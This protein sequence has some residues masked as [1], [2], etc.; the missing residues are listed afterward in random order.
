MR[1]RCDVIMRM[2]C[3][4]AFFF[5]TSTSRLP[6]SADSAFS[7]CTSPYWL[8]LLSCVI[9]ARWKKVLPIWELSTCF[10]CLTFY[11][12]ISCLPLLNYSFDLGEPRAW[13]LIR[14]GPLPFLKVP[15]LVLSLRSDKYLLPKTHN[16]TQ[17]SVKLWELAPLPNII[18]WVSQWIY[19]WRQNMEIFCCE[20]SFLA[21]RNFQG[22][23]S[24]PFF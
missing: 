18:V 5:Y 16:W 1:S 10:T 11:I 3:I 21:L 19:T 7:V 24:L 6:V 12:S 4:Y 14:Y 15:P 17:N 8:W 23:K 13:S 9:E 20:N 22:K 2:L